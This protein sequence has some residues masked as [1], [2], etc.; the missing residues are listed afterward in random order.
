MDTLPPPA[1]MTSMLVRLARIYRQGIDEALTG[2]G[3]SDALALPVI[4]LGRYPDGSRQNA[5][6]DALGVEGP[7]LVRLLDRLVEDGLVERRED[8][9]DRR[10]KIVKLTALGEAHS[11]Q[12]S[13]VLDA[14][15][16][17][18]LQGA[19]PTDI[20]ATLRVFDLMLGRLLAT[21]REHRP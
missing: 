7:S 9:A 3:L 1:K 13:R 6:A 11:L 16:A 10:A 14:F 20:E 17:S 18:L 15:R 19:A 8:P 2:L 5:L 21:R 12:A 4:V